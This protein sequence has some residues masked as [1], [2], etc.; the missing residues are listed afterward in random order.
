MDGE[1]EAK[2]EAA[3]DVSGR[4]CTSRLDPDIV[5]SLDGRNIFL[6]KILLNIPDL[7]LTCSSLGH[8][9]PI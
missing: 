3:A 8:V 5:S 6:D 2:E 7:E 1:S 9:Y 4:D